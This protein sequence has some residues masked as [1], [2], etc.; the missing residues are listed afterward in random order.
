M[1][2][3]SAIMLVMAVSQA[4]QPTT[5]PALG[6]GLLDVSPERFPVSVFQSEVAQAKQHQITDDAADKHTNTA[7]GPAFS[8]AIP[9]ARKKL[10]PNTDPMP[11]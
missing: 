7:E 11:K 4:D 10:L 2:M 9:D 8:T 3:A 5:N 6:H 1:A